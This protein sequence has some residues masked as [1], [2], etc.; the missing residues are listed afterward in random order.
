MKKK[1][2]Y[3]YKNLTNSFLGVVQEGVLYSNNVV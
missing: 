3:S 1:E 2:F